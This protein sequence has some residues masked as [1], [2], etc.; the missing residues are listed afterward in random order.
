MKKHW[1]DLPTD[2]L[3]SIRTEIGR[4][5]QLTAKYLDRL[6][7]TIK[8]ITTIIRKR[9][10]EGKKQLEVTDHAVLRYIERVHGV[11][12]NQLRE[13]IR[14]LAEQG[15]PVE[16]Y[17]KALLKK[18]NMLFVKDQKRLAD[19]MVS[20]IVTMYLDTEFPTIGDE[21]W[22]EDDAIK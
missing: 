2:E 3:V 1:K 16:G 13:I 4:K 7:G 19:G 14:A 17:G 9:E 22:E 5:I 20:P 11:D 12:V 6:H 10:S 21:L 15:T 18:D 8:S